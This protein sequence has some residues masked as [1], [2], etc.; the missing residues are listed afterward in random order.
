MKWV[1][2]VCLLCWSSMLWGHGNEKN[3]PK[4]IG[5][6]GQNNHSQN[7]SSS[8]SEEVEVESAQ[9]GFRRKRNFTYPN[10]NPK[11]EPQILANEIKK[12]SRE[13]QRPTQQVE[14]S[15]PFSAW[16]G[17]DAFPTLHPMVVHVPVV[18][19][20]FALMLFVMEWRSR[21]EKASLAVIISAMGGATGAIVASF[22]L[23]PHVASLNREA[24]AVLEAH[25]FFA[26]TTTGLASSATICLGFRHFRWNHHDRK[27]WTLIAF[28][29]LAASSLTVA[30]TGHLGAT[31]SHVHEVNISP[32]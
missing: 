15:D 20:P 3:E 26:Y 23:H 8:K 2:L 1:S 25:E 17:L 18:L 16:V 30:A 10:P 13:N 12:S 14:A 9:K 28:I 5:E 22:W 21:P 19:L 27:W 11:G 32:N 6:S 4:I 29:L 7:I 24:W 31:L